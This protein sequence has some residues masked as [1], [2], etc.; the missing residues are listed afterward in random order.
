M[1]GIASVQDVD[2]LGINAVGRNNR[3]GERARIECFSVDGKR[4]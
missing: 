3:V 2:G 4:E 1:S